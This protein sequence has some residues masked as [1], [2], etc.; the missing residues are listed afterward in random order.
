V[1]QGLKHGSVLTIT[2]TAAS[3]L[4]LLVKVCVCVPVDSFITGSYDRTCKIWD[5]ASE[6]QLHTLEGHRN[7]VYAVAYNNPFGFV[8]YCLHLPLS[9]LTEESS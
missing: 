4:R 1:P 9:I 5:T 3:D 8:S 7:V 2:V 6:E